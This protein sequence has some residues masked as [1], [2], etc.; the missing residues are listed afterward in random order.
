MVN[1]RNKGA[2]GEREV[3]AHLQPVLDRVCVATKCPQIV[4][5]RNQDQRFAAKQYDIVGIPWMA[6]EVKRVENQ[7][8]HGIETWWEQ[9]KAA[10]RPGQIPVLFYR[11]NHHPWKVRLRIW[12]KAGKTRKVK[13]SVTMDLPTFLVWFEERMLSYLEK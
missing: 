4:L 1:S 11:P 3:M 9:V 12:V 8:Q 2:G 13:C 7:Q 10:T 6:F 5:Q